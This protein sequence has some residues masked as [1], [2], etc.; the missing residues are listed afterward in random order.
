MDYQPTDLAA[1]SLFNTEDDASTGGKYY[2]DSRGFPWAM[3]FPTDFSFPKEKV[4]IRSS[5]NN[6]DNWVISAGTS[7]TDWYQAQNA[8]EGQ[9]IYIP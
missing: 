7:E 1:D 3:D 4:S 6:F 9:V 2:V 5:Y 8:A